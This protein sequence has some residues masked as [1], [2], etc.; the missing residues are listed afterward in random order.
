[1]FFPVGTG[2]R[3][4]AQVA[5]ATAVCARCPVRPACLSFA[6]VAIPD[7]I[8]GGL[9]A[10]QRRRE[11]RER[12]RAGVGSSAAPGVLRVP[13]GVDG[14]V[15]ERLVSGH[16]VGGATREERAYAAVVLHRAGRGVTAIAAGERQVYRWLER[17]AAGLPLNPGRTTR[18]R[19]AVGSARPGLGV[20][21]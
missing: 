8:A 18:Q 11:S 15:V 17:A 20:A 14:L 5:R 12:R 19:S 13:S 6:V 10:E 21:S 4:A 16:P 2:A 3:V 9:T 1:M 7:G